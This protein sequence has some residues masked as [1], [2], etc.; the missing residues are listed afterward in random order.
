MLYNRIRALGTVLTTR[1]TVSTHPTS[2]PGW[3]RCWQPSASSKTRWVK[4][5]ALCRALGGVWCD[6]EWGWGWVGVG[7]MW[8]GVGGVRVCYLCYVLC[9]AIVGQSRAEQG[10]L[11]KCSSQYL[12]ALPLPLPISCNRPS[13]VLALLSPFYSPTPA[14]FPFCSSLDSPTRSRTH[15]PATEKVITA[16]RC[17]P[18]LLLFL[19]CNLIPLQSCFECM[20]SVF[21]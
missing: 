5:L 19:H 2:C 17:N 20:S 3:W 6:T 21:L 16:D 4:R 10:R 11:L 18:H 8:S 15:T 7:A 9:A 13:F 14:P 1:V 12:V